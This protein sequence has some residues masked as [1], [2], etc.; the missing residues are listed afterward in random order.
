MRRRIALLMVVCVVGLASA[1]VS[2]I[3]ANGQAD[4]CNVITGDGSDNWKWGYCHQ[5]H[6]IC[7]GDANEVRNHTGHTIHG[8]NND[9]NPPKGCFFEGCCTSEDAVKCDQK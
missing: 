5:G 3:R 7:T 8:T 2:S 4:P 1:Y 9:S 6:P